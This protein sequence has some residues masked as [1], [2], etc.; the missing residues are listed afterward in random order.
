MRFKI[1]LK[2]NLLKNKI[3]HDKISEFL[4]NIN[5]Y[6]TYVLYSFEYF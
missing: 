2:I 1:R 3:I 5:Y 4:G 6:L